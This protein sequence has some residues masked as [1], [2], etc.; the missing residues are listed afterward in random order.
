MPSVSILGTTSTSSGDGGGVCSKRRTL[1]ER[2]ACELV[3][4]CVAMDGDFRSESGDVDSES[5]DL[6]IFLEEGMC[7]SVALAPFNVESD[8]WER[9][10]FGR[11]MPR[12]G[13]ER[14]FRRVLYGMFAKRRS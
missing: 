2:P 4:S 11:C 1:F 10:E 5:C 7:S 9:D 12:D 6:L 3:L 13:S 8:L 14:L